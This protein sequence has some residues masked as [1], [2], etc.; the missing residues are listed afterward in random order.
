MARA[1]CAC[2]PWIGAGRDDELFVLA[3]QHV[4]WAHPEVERSDDEIRERVAA[5]ASRVE[6]CC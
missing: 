3:R 2:G 5:D 6:S 1:G 4:D